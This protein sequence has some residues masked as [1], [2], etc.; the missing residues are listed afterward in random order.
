VYFQS[1]STSEE[2]FTISSVVVDVVYGQLTQQTC[3]AAVQI[4]RKTSWKFVESVFSRT[5][6][7]GPGYIKG[8]HI[9]TGVAA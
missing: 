5:N 9:L 6:S 3:G 8:R 4:S 2:K 1:S 7:G